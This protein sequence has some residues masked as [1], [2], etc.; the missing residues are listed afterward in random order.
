MTLEQPPNPSSKFVSVPTESVRACV[1]KTRCAKTSPA[2]HRSIGFF[3]AILMAIALPAFTGCG[4]YSSMGKTYPTNPSTGQ[5]L[6]VANGTNVLEFETISFTAMSNPVFPPVLVLNSTAFAAPQGVIF[7]TSAN[8]W[9]IDGGNIGTGGK[10]TPALYEFTPSQLSA[11]QSGSGVTPNMTINSSV[12]VFPQQAVWDSKGNLWISDNGANAVFE[13]TPAQL[14][15]SG[16]NVT[17]NITIKSNPAFN[18]GFGASSVSALGI[19]LDSAGDLWVAN[20]GANTIVEF[21]A[22][23]LPTTGGS[24]TITPNVVLS[25]DGNQSIQGPW[26][27]AFDSSGNLWSS[28]AGYYGMINNLIHAANTV[29]EFPKASLAASGSPNPAVTLSS[30][31]VD[32]NG[33][34]NFPKGIAFDSSGDLSVVS[35]ATPFGVGIYSASQL[36]AGGAVA[37][38]VSIMGA[39]T[40]LNAPAGSNYGPTITYGNSGGGTYS[41][42]MY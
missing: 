26:A 8:L 27:L 15:A 35:S 21:N 17:P 4:S 29:V 23:A 10:V 40:T 6:W 2:K 13:F 37:P 34:L 22:A 36:T 32:G 11:I 7:D 12:F 5:A 24:V 30:A 20:N 33:S 14:M 3:C 1:A 25:D 28:N 39:A 41:G 38:N 31:M 19:A 16:T 42:G 18:G 9:V